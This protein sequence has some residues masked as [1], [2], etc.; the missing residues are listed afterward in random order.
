MSI[1]IANESG[2]PADV[3]QIVSV[4]A[5]AVN[6][7]GLHPECE[8]EILLVN[9]ERI[10]ELHV[11]WMDLPGP[12]DV[13]SFPMDELAPNSA[14]D[15]PGIIGDI[16]LCPQFAQQQVQSGKTAKSD[17]NQELALLTVHGV[18]HC[19]G[20]DHAEPDEERTM[21]ALQEKILQ[22]WQ[23]SAR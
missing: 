4:A 1:E 13:L 20:F 22:D 23:A 21:F 19:I 16:V 12:T 8:L 14:A 11:E 3:D 15:G 5:F 10:S 9:E 18:L 17:L 2:M 6:A 7:M